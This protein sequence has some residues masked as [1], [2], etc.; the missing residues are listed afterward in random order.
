MSLLGLV[1]EVS[2]G[3]RRRGL[4]ALRDRL[5]GDLEWAERA[6]DVA[7]LSRQLS[8]AMR[9]LGELD[10]G[11]APASVGVEVKT[12]LDELTKRR[13]SRGAKPARKTSAKVA[14]D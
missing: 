6:S 1:D 2:S 12:P 4:V 8:D 3:D 5:A 11:A 13:A 7:A 9:Q 14:G 10:A